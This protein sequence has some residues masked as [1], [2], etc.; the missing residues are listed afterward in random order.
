ML[1]PGATVP[2]VGTLANKLLRVP[3]PESNPPLTIALR[4]GG[5]SVSVSL[6]PEDEQETK[7]RAHIVDPRSGVAIRER[8]IAVAISPSATDAEV[9]T[10]AILLDGEAGFLYLENFPGAE[11]ALLQPDGTSASSSGFDRFVEPAQ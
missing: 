10:K 7:L 4:D 6:V 8:R 11:A 3:V 2:P 1:G 9:L 5:L